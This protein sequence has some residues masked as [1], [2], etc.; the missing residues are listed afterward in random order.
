[1]NRPHLYKHTFSRPEGVPIRIELADLLD[2]WAGGAVLLYPADLDKGPAHWLMV[3]EVD[4]V[5][6]T[7]PLAPPR[8]HNPA[9]CRPIGIYPASATEREA[10]RHDI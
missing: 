6:V 9:K 1:M 2:L 4:G 8:S 5:V 7:V 10:Y 3:G